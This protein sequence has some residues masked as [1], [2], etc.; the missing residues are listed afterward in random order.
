MNT[1]M[2]LGLSLGAVIAL[3]III[4]V[5]LKFYTLPTK[6]QAFVRTGAGGQKTVIDGGVFVLPG[7]HEVIW[8]NLK[9]IRLSVKR[10]GREALITRDRMLVDISADFF[11][12]VEPTV[13]SISMAATTLG[14]LTLD[15]ESLAEQ[16]ESKFVDALRAVAAEMTM[17]QLHEARQNFVRKVQET[18]AEDLTRNGL[19]LETV[20]L[21]SFNQTPKEYFDPNNAFHAEGL[22]QLTNETESRRKS[23]NAVTADT[24]VEI[25]KKNLE[26]RQATLQLDRLRADAEARQQQEVATLQA[27]QQATM[28]RNVAEA[29]RVSETAKIEANQAV[30]LTKVSTDQSL[31]ERKV[32]AE[33]R[34]ALA[35][36]NQNIEIANRS[37][38][39]AQASAEADAVKAIAIAAEEKVTTAR[40]VEIAE[41]GKSVVLVK[42]KEDAERQAL[43]VTVA[44]T[45]EKEAAT[46][47]AEAQRVTA[48]GLRD[49]ALLS[50]EGIQATGEAEAKALAAKVEAQNA[51]N[52]ALISQQVKL[53]LLRVLPAIIA[54]SVKPIENIDSIRIADIRGLGTS[55]GASSSGEGGSG[56]STGGS[57]GGLAD[58]VVN[59]A[60]RYRTQ[61]PMIDALMGEVGLK[62]GG[63]ISQ[64][65]DGVT[66]TVLSEGSDVDYTAVPDHT[67]DYD[68]VSITRNAN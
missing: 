41:R 22:S 64:M 39:E 25:E 4:A 56:D 30:E 26:A 53:E 3:A 9:T 46:D 68:S 19:Q 48:T 50:A 11:V 27:E 63:N 18:V 21:T 6:E 67:Q 44:A 7:L 2:I 36:Q 24:Q 38:D 51:L 20:S 40:D 66:K 60:L 62:S 35:T 57:G 37:K 65:M 31:R 15:S 8:V 1:Y 33:T 61:G 58:Q 13:E 52:P 45:A 28:D 29:H 5:A 12:R 34:I 32:E 59:G 55:G 14:Q 10:T 42:A 16:I 43:A 54:E 49:A 23:I 47:R 17:Y